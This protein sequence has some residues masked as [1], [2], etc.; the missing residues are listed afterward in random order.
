NPACFRRPALCVA[1]GGGCAPTHSYTD[2]VLGA[3]RDRGEWFDGMTVHEIEMKLLLDHCE[4]QRGLQH[5][6][7]RSDA[8][9]RTTAKREIGE[10]RNFSR[11]DGIFAP[12]L[13]V[14]CVRIGEETRVAL[15]Q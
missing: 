12:A 5:G 11:A 10:S 15:R 13:R 2:A 14:K 9:P 6:E 1:L 7:R 8:Y 3:Q 4:Q